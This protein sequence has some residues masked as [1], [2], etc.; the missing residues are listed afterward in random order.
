MMS[1]ERDPWPDC[2]HCARRRRIRRRPEAKRRRPC[3]FSTCAICMWTSLVFLEEAPDIST[4]L[5]ERKRTS[6]SRRRPALKDDGGRRHR[7]ERRRDETG[8][9]MIRC[10]IFSERARQNWNPRMRIGSASSLGLDTL[11]TCTTLLEESL[12]RTKGHLHRLARR[13]QPN[14]TP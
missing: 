4:W 2:G 6:R 14:P 8:E 9:G 7:S 3:S 12:P 1:S 5:W 10:E 11:P 13:R